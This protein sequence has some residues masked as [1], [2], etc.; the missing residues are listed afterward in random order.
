MAFEPE[1][2]PSLEEMRVQC[3]RMLQITSE[4]IAAGGILVKPGDLVVHAKI[5][6]TNKRMV[7][8]SA[9]PVVVEYLQGLAKVWRKRKCTQAERDALAKATAAAGEGDG[10]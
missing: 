1:H 10:S 7:L 2:M 6:G 4:A 5:D 3:E 8:L 9:P